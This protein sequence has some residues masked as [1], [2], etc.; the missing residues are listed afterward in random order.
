MTAANGPHV[1]RQMNA[2]TVW[3]ALRSATAEGIRVTEISR[4]TGLSR[5]AV[6]RA[7]M[8]LDHAGLVESIDETDRLAVGRPAVRYAFRADTGY[9][10]GIDVGPHKILVVIADLRGRP[11]AEHRV[12]L[13][14]AATGNTIATQL[15]SAL[16][17]AMAAAEI[18]RSDL[19][20]IAIGTPGVVDHAR[21]EV[22]LAPSIPRWSGRPMLASLEKWADCTI[23]ID[24]DA[25]MA[26]LAEYRHGDQPA[27]LLF[28]HWGERVGAGMILDGRIYRGAHSAAGELGFINVGTSLDDE[29]PPIAT[30]RLG[31]FEY[32]VG[33]QELLRLARTRATP[34][35]SARINDEGSLVPLFEAADAGEPRAVEIVDLIARRFARGVAMYTLVFDP[36]EV[37]IGGGLS[38]G[39]PT[40]FAAIDRYLQPQLLHPVEIRTSPLHDSGVAVGATY[41]ALDRAEARILARIDEIV[42]GDK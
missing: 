36:D 41:V 38:R 4:T 29:V 27:S 6:T 37:V 16:A 17:E 39:G 7:L 8:T 34:D 15:E 24:N 18:A 26:A 3:R 21:G 19:W 35:V 33:A 23:V 12:G 42:T 30:E 20:G 22:A 11:I 14:L 5:P 10:A 31:S 13:P 32:M 28:I 1:L 25:N 9:V 2:A 40:L